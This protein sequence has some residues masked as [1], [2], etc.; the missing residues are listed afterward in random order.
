MPKI[1]G[2]SRRARLDSSLIHETGTKLKKLVNGK[3]ISIRKRDYL[4]RIFVCPGNF[5]VG[6]TKKNVYHLH[7]NRNFRK[8]VVNGKHSLLKT[9]A[10]ATCIKLIEPYFKN[11]NSK[12]FFR[13][14][15]AVLTVK[16]I[17]KSHLK[18]GCPTKPTRYKLFKHVKHGSIFGLDPPQR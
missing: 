1:S 11:M 14:I 3:R 17:S 4:F 13:I 6:R 9:S 10:S 15:T 8:F 7:P 2:L 12:I 5:Q 16:H 18:N